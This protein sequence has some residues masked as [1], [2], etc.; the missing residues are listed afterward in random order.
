[1]HRVKRI[2]CW[3]QIFSFRP[4]E[5]A[6]WLR[7]QYVFSFWNPET[8]FICYS[9]R[10]VSVL[11]DWPQRSRAS[12]SAGVGFIVSKASYKCLWFASLPFMVLY[13]AILILIYIKYWNYFATQILSGFSSNFYVLRWAM[14]YL[15]RTGQTRCGVTPRFFGQK[16]VVTP[17]F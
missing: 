2:L 11:T 13:F 5:L 7:A 1:M 15:R 17:A 4:H 6:K 16:F 10:R 12:C 9:H 8:H 14:D 3:T